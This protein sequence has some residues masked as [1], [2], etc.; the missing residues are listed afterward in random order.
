MNEP[1]D[2]NLC[3]L[4]M[5]CQPAAREAAQRLQ[6]KVSIE[7]EE[8]LNAGFVVPGSAV[9]VSLAKIFEQTEE[10]PGSG[11]ALR[12]EITD[13][14]RLDLIC[15]FASAI[16]NLEEQIHITWSSHWCQFR[17]N[18]QAAKTIDQAIEILHRYNKGGQESL[19]E[20]MKTDVQS[21]YEQE[22]YDR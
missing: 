17:E 4:A 20:K 2:F 1:D 15:H 9:W 18:S 6:K 5:E 22:I 16:L 10:M 3:S 12:I 11:S 19:L 21:I 8:R 13:T 14:Q 7:A